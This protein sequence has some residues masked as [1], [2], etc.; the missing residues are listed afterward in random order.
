M[1]KNLKIFDLFDETKFQTFS[2][3]FPKYVLD[4]LFK[5][6]PIFFNPIK[7][8]NEL[9]WDNLTDMYQFI[10]LNSL[11]KTVPEI[12]KLLALILS[13]PPTSASN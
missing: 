13:L 10:S 1:N 11:Q 4:R 3:D 9:K 2:K 5:N 12:N 7:L 8:E 6:Y